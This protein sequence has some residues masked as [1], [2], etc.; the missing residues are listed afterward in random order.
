VLAA[1]AVWSLTGLAVRTIDRADGLQ[2]TFYRSVGLVPVMLAFIAVRRRGRVIQAFRGA[3]WRA[4]VAG[5]FMAASNMAAI[6]ALLNTTVANTTFMLGLGPLLT[7]VAGRALFKER[8]DRSAWWWFLVAA[9]GVGIMTAGAAGGGRMFGNLMALL[10][11]VTYAGFSLTIQH[12]R[13]TDMNPAIVWA[14]VFAGVASFVA[15]ADLVVPRSDAVTG[16]LIGAAF[17]GGG[18]VLYVAGSL[19]V[20]AAELVLL[21]LVEIVLAP[22]WVW[23]FF[24]ER[25]APATLVGGAVVMAAVMARAQGQRSSSIRNPV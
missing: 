12:G 24:A 3:G 22:T 15:S 10:M 16:V 25:P 23:I 5:L 18:L 7:A 14:G 17:L 20:P 4:V 13:A 21:G 6:F 8:L 19:S 9:G 2:I 1:G 11:V